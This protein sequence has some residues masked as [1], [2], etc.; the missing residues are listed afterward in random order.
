MKWDIEKGDEIKFFDPK[1]TYELTKYRPIDSENGF[2]FDPTPFVEVGV[3]KDTTGKYTDMPIGSKNHRDWWKEQFR[4]CKEGYEYNGYRVTGD[5]Y[6]FLNFYRLLNVSKITKSGEGRTESMPSFWAKN[7]EYFHYIEMCEHLNKD[8]ISFKA[9]G[10]GFSEMAT[11]LGVRPYITTPNYQSIFVAFSEGLLEPT[12]SKV[13]AQLEYLN[14]ETETAMKRLRQKIDTNMWKRASL[15]DRDKNEKGHKSELKGVIVDAARKLRGRRVDRL[16]YEESGSNPILI[17]TYIKGE[18][19]VEING[20]KIGTRVVFGTGGDEGKPLEGLE[21]MFLNVEAFNGLPYRHNHTRDGKYTLTG[22]FIPAYTS[23]ID[24][25]DHR[26]VTDEE[27]GREYYMEK[28]KRL[29]HLPKELMDYCAEYCFFPEEALNKQ[30]QNDFNQ[31]LL[32]QQYTELE[33]HKSMPKPER[34]RL[35][36][37]KDKSDN[38]V[39]VK[40]VKDISGPIL[41][42]EHP[43]RDEQNMVTKNLYV[44]GV[45]SIDQGQED[46]TVG[47]RG[48]KFAIS[49]KKRKF[50]NGGDDYVCVYMERPQDVRT[51]Y[52]NAAMILWYYGCKANLEYSKISFRT[53]LREKNLD[54]KLLMKRPSAAIKNMKKAVTTLW[55]TPGTEEMIKHGLKLVKFYIEDHCH[56]ISFIDMITQL[57]RFNYDDKGNFD[58]VMSMVMCE[59]GDEDMYD[60]KINQTYRSSESWQD[61]GY[62]RDERGVKRWGVIPKQED[63][64]N[65]NKNFKWAHQLQ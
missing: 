28:R 40:W 5:H 9:R 18:A 60:L 2:D 35:F 21:K 12:L 50:G 25:M 13:W 8:V 39:G 43:I 56:K 46:S 41:I 38:I 14:T 63:I 3:K 44:G 22:F 17:E 24:L 42:K 62:Y 61:V 16:I 6:F 29:A 37:V 11:C 10:V 57:Q 49:I 1:L 7:Y 53:W 54:E 58:L 33:I 59:I 45:D 32:A 19:L 55:G 34:G 36:W 4:R 47:D 48:S 64:A 23:V 31:V 26:G 20:V 65:I 51:A 30:G 27:A 52:T 15:I